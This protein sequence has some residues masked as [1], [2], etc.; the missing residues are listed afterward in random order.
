MAIVL[1]LIAVSNGSKISLFGFFQP[2]APL[3]YQIV[4]IQYA[5]TIMG[6]REVSRPY[7]DGLSIDEFCGF[8]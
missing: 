8:C 3:L 7:Q 2:C 6:G 1:I 5:T 4:S